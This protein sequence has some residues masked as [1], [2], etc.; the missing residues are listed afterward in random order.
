MV[1]FWR[2][3]VLAILILGIFVLISYQATVYIDSDLLHAEDI[4]MY[5]KNNKRTIITILLTSLII[6]LSTLYIT[7]KTPKGEEDEQE[8]RGRQWTRKISTA[9]YNK[10]IEK[11]TQESLK[12]LIES[13]EYQQ[14]LAA[15][16][17]GTLKPLVLEDDDEIILSDD[18]IE[19]QLDVGND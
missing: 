8:S 3:F 7:Y 1:R 17:S 11:E 9:S 14:F 13:T 6:L 4:I 18:E 19:N 12:Q 2:N 16:S 5:I 10:M 15:K